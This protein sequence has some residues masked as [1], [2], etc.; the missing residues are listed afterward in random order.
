MSF[1]LFVN[2]LVSGLVATSFLS[3]SELLSMSGA[4]GA[5]GVIA[6]SSFVFVWIYVPETKGKSLEEMH[7]FF[8]SLVDGGGSAEHVELEDFDDV[9]F[10]DDFDKLSSECRTPTHVAMM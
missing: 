8:A 7:D 1:G 10:E 4:F 6:V 5:F 2:R 9:E 3:I